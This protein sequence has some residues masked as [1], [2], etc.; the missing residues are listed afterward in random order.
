M[1]GGDDL[2]FHVMAFGIEIL[3]RHL[4]SSHGSWSA[5]IRVKPGHIAEHA[6]LDGQRGVATRL[7]RLGRSGA[8]RDDHWHHER[9]C[10]SHP[11]LTR[12]GAP[13]GS[14]EMNAV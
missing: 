9:D 12:E 4:R 1:I 7:L 14:G 6:N 5:Y 8:E 11:R 10:C 3:D 2:D 13:K